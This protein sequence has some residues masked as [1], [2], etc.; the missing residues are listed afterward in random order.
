[1]ASLPLTRTS[2]ELLA[3]LRDPGNEAAWSRYVER[4]RPLI[5]AYARRAGLAEADAEDAAQASLLSFSDGLRRNRY[6][7]EQG[8]LR[9]WLHGIAVNKVREVRRA[10]RERQA[11]DTAEESLLD[12]VGPDELEASWEEEWRDAVLRQCLAEVRAEVEPN[13]LRA[14]ELSAREGWPAERVARELGM[15]KDAVYAAKRRVLRR[16]RELVPLIEEAF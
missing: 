14:F 4:Y 12:P 5:L 2:T 3:D 15:T 16:V 10:R 8:R 1:M 7:R 11:A 6:E 13:T 9:S